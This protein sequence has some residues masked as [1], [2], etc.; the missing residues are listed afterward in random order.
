[1]YGVGNGGFHV[2]ERVVF[3][4]WAESEDDIDHTD[5]EHH[6]GPF[7]GGVRSIHWDLIEEPDK[8]MVLN[9]INN[10]IRTGN[11]YLSMAQ[12]LKEKYEI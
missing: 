1:M 5:V 3:I 12:R 8:E 2:N 7:S 6:V 10:A 4:S 11:S 9:E